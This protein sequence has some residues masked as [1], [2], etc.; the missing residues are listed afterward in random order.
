MS[1]WPEDA[2]QTRPRTTRRPTLAGGKTLNDLAGTM[3]PRS[4]AARASRRHRH[5]TDT[6]AGPPPPSHAFNGEAVGRAWHQALEG[7]Q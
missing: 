7:R 4:A 3:I 5:R 6:I 2:P 1:T